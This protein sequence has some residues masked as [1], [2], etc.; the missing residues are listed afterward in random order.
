MARPKTTP[1]ILRKRRKGKD[2]ITKR[3]W[4]KNLLGEA[5]TK[6]PEPMELLK[7]YAT[8]EMVGNRGL[9]K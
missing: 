8:Q 3:D 9:Y 4:S 6:A 1:T 7:F 5:F 2:D